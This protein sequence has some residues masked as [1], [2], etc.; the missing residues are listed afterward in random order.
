MSAKIY[1]GPGRL[2]RNQKAEEG[3]TFTL[4]LWEQNETFDLLEHRMLS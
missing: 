1:D 3:V 4:Q 2:P